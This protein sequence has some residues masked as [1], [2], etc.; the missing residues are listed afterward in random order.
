MCGVASRTSALNFY[1][2]PRA[3]R[4]RETN[5]KPAPGLMRTIRQK[6]RFARTRMTVVLNDAR[7]LREKEMEHASRGLSV[8]PCKI[9]LLNPQKIQSSFVN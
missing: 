3:S 1:R 4:I 6:S 5:G 9:I 8:V 2:L 7:V